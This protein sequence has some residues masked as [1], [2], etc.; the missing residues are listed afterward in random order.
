MSVMES[1]SGSEPDFPV[2]EYQQRVRRAQVLMQENGLD[3][4]MITGDLTS[5]A[6]YRYFSGHVCRDYQYNHTRPHV[7]LLTKDGSASLLVH[8]L[9]SG[10]AK[11]L[12][13]VK[14]IKSYG[15]PFRFEYVRENIQAL[16]LGSAV[17]GCELGVG[18]RLMMPVAEFDKLRES[19]PNAKFADAS[20][21][22]WNMRLIKSRRES[23]CIRTAD[24]MNG[25]AL[26]N[27][28]ANLREGMSEIEAAKVLA[29]FI[30][31]EGSWRPPVCMMNFSS[32]P[33][34]TSFMS[35]KNRSL[36]RGDMI[37]ID[38]GC[39][40]KGYWGEFVRTGVVGEPSE[41]QKKEHGIVT[42]S[43][44]RT[45]EEAIKPGVKMSEA[46]KF[47]VRILKDDY[48]LDYEAY[49]RYI[50]SKT[51]LG[52]G[53]GLHSSE[54]PYITIDNDMTFKPGMTLCIEAHLRT[55]DKLDTE[56][57]ILITEDGCDI[58]TERY[59]NRRIYSIATT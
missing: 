36:K 57:S 55:D 50:E 49:K 9:T 51:F 39:V 54:L 7:L 11:L 41:K 14:D 45:I 23:D 18:Q 59:F 4:L 58:L 43:V 19:L 46:V 53:L 16:G 12:S 15:E 20:D 33:D 3:A 56:E 34:W 38:S 31:D 30:I 21:L 52:H 47:F 10:S 44:R 25:R 1:Q 2:E 48:K 17:I 5:S 6:N 8:V 29:K 35:A 32:P 40:F 37:S 26:E 28:Y 13:W 42:N 27:M 22:I 24:E